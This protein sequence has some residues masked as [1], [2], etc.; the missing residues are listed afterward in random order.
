MNIFVNFSKLHS[1]LVQ[2]SHRPLSGEE[3]FRDHWSLCSAAT[4]LMQAWLGG[5]TQRPSQVL[6]GSPGSSKVHGH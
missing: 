3:G 5:E 2:L 6:Q 4:G 1:L